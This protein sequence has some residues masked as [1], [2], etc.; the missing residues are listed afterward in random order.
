MA[1][2]AS[3]VC[4]SSLLAPSIDQPN[5]MVDASDKYLFVSCRRL[6]TLAIYDRQ[7]LSGLP[8]L[9]LAVPM[10]GDIKAQGA[11][12][13]GKF[14]IVY[15]LDN[16]KVWRTLIWDGKLHALPD[17]PYWESVDGNKA[18]FLKYI[19]KDL[20]TSLQITFTYGDGIRARST[21]ADK[22]WLID[23]NP[24]GHDTEG[25]YNLSQGDPIVNGLSSEGVRV[26]FR[27]SPLVSKVLY[28]KAAI[29]GSPGQI[30]RDNNES[31]AAVLFCLYDR[32]EY[33]LLILKAGSQQGKLNRF[34]IP[35]KH[36]GDFEDSRL[37]YCR[38]KLYI[39]KDCYSRAP[40]RMQFVKEVKIG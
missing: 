30:L 20:Q 26:P 1:F 18:A 35:I 31:Q 12:S 6:H 21:F 8:K 32:P 23:F 34:S 9:K 33:R 25:A 11:F 17:I 22:E 10:T 14:A 29:E 24:K 27:T 36:Q 28:E 19:N 39:W 15:A 3:L 16:L 37:E 13:N 4:F 38:G 5:T 40:L 2:F 7:T